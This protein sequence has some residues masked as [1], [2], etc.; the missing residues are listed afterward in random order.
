MTQD[1]ASYYKDYW[2]GEEESRIQRGYYDRL[3]ARLKHRLTVGPTDRVLDVAGGNGQL[4]KYLGIR[5]ADLLD[6]SDSGL[7][8]ARAAGFGAI[9]GDVEKR[10]PIEENTYSVVFLFEVLEHLH[11]PLRTLTEVHH[12]L[13]PGGALY[14]GQPNMRADGVHHVRR[15]YPAELLADLRKTGFT[16]EWVDYVP[17]Y[18]MRDAIWSDIRVNRSWIR[19]AIQCVNLT[20]SFLPWS[21][22]HRLAHLLPS[23]FALLAVVKAVKKS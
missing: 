10:F 8:A 7:E 18:S 14:V 13:K 22:R 21:V 17:A 19:K 12:V 11:A 23:R 2:T 5:R 6:I 3:Y 1:A 4:L 9:R 20:L 16:I 15:Y